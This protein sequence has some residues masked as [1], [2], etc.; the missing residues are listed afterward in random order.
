VPGK[1]TARYSLDRIKAAFANPARLNRTLSAAEGAEDLGMEEQAVVDVIAALTPADFEKSIR[2]NVDRATWQD[3]YK[4][5]AGRRE[6]YVK[7]TLDAR[8]ALL[9]ISLKGND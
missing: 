8:R 9:L 7:F 3:V 2:S 4:P 1:R 5:M 6:L